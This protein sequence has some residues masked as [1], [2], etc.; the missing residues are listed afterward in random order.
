M[1]HS[2]DLLSQARHLAGKEPRRPKQ[3][4]LRRAVSA[5][6]YSLFHLLVADAASSML[7]GKPASGIRPVFQRAF[8]HAHMKRVARSF[9]GG[10]VSDAWK[11]PMGGASVSEDLRQV[12]SAFVNLQEARHKADYDLGRPF[13]RREARDLIEDAERAAGS[14]RNV[15]NDLE[16]QVFL[17]ALL[18]DD[19]ISRVK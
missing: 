13:S 18:V 5:A 10:T 16:G 12:A 17:T 9:A 2:S 11:G 3:A 7:R 4:S 8:A 19:R 15:R 6:Y 14:W 1:S